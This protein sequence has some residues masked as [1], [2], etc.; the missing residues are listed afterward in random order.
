MEQKRQNSG[1]AKRYKSP[2]ANGK[3]DGRPKVITTVWADEVADAMLA[4]FQQPKNFWL[5]DFARTVIS[6]VT[7]MPY[8]WNALVDACKCSEKFSVALKICHEIQ[9]SKL[10]TIGT[11]APAIAIFA[12]KNVAG[13]RDKPEDVDDDGDALDVEF[14]D[15]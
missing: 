11:K 3:K 8:Y 7:G 9:E 10:F 5:K 13:W 14:V 4:W 12:L 2:P 1:K 15:E 6:P